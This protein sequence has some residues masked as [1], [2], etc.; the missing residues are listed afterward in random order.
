MTKQKEKK[1]DRLVH[2]LASSPKF[3]AY[4]AK[5]NKEILRNPDKFRDL[6]ME[7]R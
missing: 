7:E 4:I 3:N 2:E 6:A 5:T 1:I